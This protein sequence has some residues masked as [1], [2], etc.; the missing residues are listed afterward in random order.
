MDHCIAPVMGQITDYESAGMGRCHNA[1]HIGMAVPR[2][3]SPLA[4]SN[5]DAL[6][7]LL[8]LHTDHYG[9]SRRTWCHN[10]RQNPA[11]PRR[12]STSIHTKS[13]THNIQFIQ[14]GEVFY[15]L[16]TTFLKISLGLFFLRLLTKTWQRRLFHAILG[17]SATYGLYYFFETIFHCGNPAKMG[18]ALLGSRNCAPAALA[19]TSGYIY[20][21]INVL[22]D[23]I[24]TLIPIVLLIDSDIDRRS[25]ISVG[26]VMGFAAVGSISSILRMVYLKGLMLRGSI[27]RTCAPFFPILCPATN[28]L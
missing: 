24:F 3:N 28:K 4:H 19:L 27:S 21:V 17:I 7:M 11:K 18:Y 6:Y 14:L 1:L 12:K 5:P 8:C 2:R 25:K 10:A 16:T 13:H 26:I 15:I 22:A 20:G 9:R 23:W